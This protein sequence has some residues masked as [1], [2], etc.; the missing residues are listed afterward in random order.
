MDNFWKTDNKSSGTN[1]L[2]R[3]AQQHQQMFQHIINYKSNE[4]KKLRYTIQNTNG[5]KVDASEMLRELS[6]IDKQ[7]KIMMG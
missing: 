3:K 5:E 1:E 6:K 4:G 2:R 7:P